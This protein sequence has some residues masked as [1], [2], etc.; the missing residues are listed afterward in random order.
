MPQTRK[1]FAENIDILFGE[2]ELAIQWGRPS[3]LLAIH[4]SQLSK[5]RA[6]AALADRLKKLGQGVRQI[7][8]NSGS[9]DVAHEI[10][11]S[12]DLDR[13]VFFISNVDWG[14]A[15][16]G[17]ETY[18]A[19]NLY[20]ELFVENKI[21]AV[22][23]LTMNEAV[24]L[25]N[26]APDFWAFRHQVV[27]FESARAFKARN[28]PVG[29]LLWHEQDSSGPADQTR[30]KIRAREKLLDE[31]P[32]RPESLATRLELLYGLA[33]LYWGLGESTKA[34]QLLSSGASL[35]END[36]LGRI[37][38]WLMN[39][40]VII[41]YEQREFR[42]CEEMLNDLLGQAQTDGVLLLNLCATLCTL[43]KNQEAISAGRKAVELEPASP[44]I[45]NR[46]G[47]VYVSMGKPD[48]AV[49]F[50]KQAIELSPKDV[51]FHESLSVC[52]SVMGLQ[53]E[54]LVE[55][56]AARS[57]AGES[58]ALAP[59]YE[60]AILDK[61]DEAIQLLRPLIDSAQVAKFDLQ[62]NPNLHLLLDDDQLQGIM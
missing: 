18:K 9:P 4:K 12:N 61:Q 29:I 53:D 33:Q 32:G 3:I 55:I 52:L 43:G 62:R 59:V 38:S 22:F 31:L 26:H 48:E 47:Y 16:D 5:S 35:A 36:Q 28:L 11:R 39:G 7:E 40:L 23:W 58:D 34:F 30:D 54:A 27:E 46:L 15:E 13:T 37:R 10:L 42:R 44:R 51:G 57:I 25:P 8:V 60:E 50:F 24:N 21:R 41:H 45:W 56:R 19:L 49:P 6:E 2:L 20:R 1:P 14:G 17:K